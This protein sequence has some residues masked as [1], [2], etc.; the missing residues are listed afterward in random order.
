MLIFGATGSVVTLMSA[1]RERFC[2]ARSRLW[3][4]AP[5]SM[6]RPIARRHALEAVAVGLDR[7]VDRR[8]VAERRDLGH[9]PGQDPG[10]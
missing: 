4:S 5:V 10:A 1:G 8:H 3:C 2:A 7:R 9:E 6:R